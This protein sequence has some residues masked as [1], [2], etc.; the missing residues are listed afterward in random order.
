VL[1]VGGIVLG[2]AV[3]IAMHTASQSMF[4]AFDKTVDQIAGST[5]LAVSAGEFGFDEAMLERIQAVPE[6]G[7]AAPIIE[8]TVEIPASAQGSILILGVDMTGRSQPPR[9]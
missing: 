7:V 5:Q 1:T 6:V 8:A 4:G 2:V 3:F 9:L